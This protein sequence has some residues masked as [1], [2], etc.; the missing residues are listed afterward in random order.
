MLVDPNELALVL[1]A[2]SRDL[3][4]WAIYAALASATIGWTWGIVIVVYWAKLKSLHSRP[5]LAAAG[6]ITFVLGTILYFAV[7]QP[8]FY[9]DQ[10]FVILEDQ[11]DLS[12]A[13]G[14]DDVDERRAFVYETLASHANGAQQD[15]TTKLARFGI[16]FRPYYLVN[17]LSLNGG[18]VIAAWLEAQPGVDRVLLNPVLRPL[19]AAAPTAVGDVEAPGGPPWNIELIGASQVWQDFGVTGSGIVVGQ[20]DSGVDGE[21]NELKANYRGRSDGNDYNWYDP[22]NGSN[23]PV[24]IGGHGTHTLATAVGAKTGVAPG[25]EWIGCVNLARN[26]ANPSLYLDC[27]QFMLA[28]YPQGGDPFT[29][30]DPSQAAD[31]LNNSWGCP[32]IEGCDPD[33]LLA[34]VQALRNA[35]I[36]VV[37]S[38]GNEGPLCESVSDPLAIY[39]EVLSVGAVDQEGTLAFFS[40]VGPV[41]VDGSGRTKPDILAPGVAVL[42]AFPGN[43]YEYLDGTSM[44]G[45]H[46]AGVVALMWSAN[47]MLR[48]DVEQTEQILM[49]TTFDYE[50]LPPACGNQ[51]LPPY[52][53]TGFG[54]VDAYSAVSTALELSE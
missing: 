53:G 12:A 49:E 24:D 21:H 32:P 45:P 35:G 4:Q 17:S 46:L 52:N 22:W 3:L 47:P 15:L 6:A 54:M 13:V 11:A 36:F 16:E 50:G 33:S 51:S 5:I 10:L 19:R 29:D 25:A 37:V 31:V 30:G 26:L 41:T 28:P 43:T 34:A 7:G 1:A 2:G 9:G 20:S 39:D 44:A 18:P 23:R 8:G 14:I 40:S 48:G 42:S 27:L 38:A